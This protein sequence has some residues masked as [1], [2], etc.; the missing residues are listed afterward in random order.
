MTFRC[1]CMCIL[2]F[3]DTF[4]IYQAHHSST[5]YY[6]TMGGATTPTNY[7]CGSEIHENEIILVSCLSLFTMEL[8]CK[9]TKRFSH[10]V[11]FKD[12]YLLVAN[13][14]LMFIHCILYAKKLLT[15]LELQNFYSSPAIYG[16]LIL[17]IVKVTF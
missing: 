13:I 12:F 16:T 8:K 1:N 3:Q 14:N 6:Y 2:Q 17:H 5:I 9:M 15:Q 10:K 7:S 11:F 4:L